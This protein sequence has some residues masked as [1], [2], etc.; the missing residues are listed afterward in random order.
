M[1]PSG[2]SRI[3]RFKIDIRDDTAMA[4]TLRME[5][6]QRYYHSRHS[7]HYLF[8][9][10]Y[11]MDLLRRQFAG[12]ECELVDITVHKAEPYI[13]IK[14]LLGAL[15]DAL[16][17]KTTLRSEF[18]LQP[19]NSGRLYRAFINN[20]FNLAPGYR[21]LELG[22]HDG[23]A[24]AAALSG[25]SIEALAVDDWSTKAGARLDFMK[26]LLCVHAPASRFGMLDKRM[27]GIFP[28]ALG[29]RSALVCQGAGAIAPGNGVIDVIL[30]STAETPALLVVDAWNFAPRRKD[31]AEVIEK[32]R[33]EPAVS[34]CVRTSL[35]GVHWGAKRNK[36]WA[37]GYFIA[38]LVPREHKKSAEP[39]RVTPESTPA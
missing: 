26:N 20:Y 2:K 32:S 22:S 1:H 25:N 29:P 23:A 37:E 17:Q 14:K 3:I 27:G 33:F 10:D 39:G 15:S 31:W 34:V 11:D 21:Y 5:Q 30:E 6:M 18:Y 19:G 4:A 13:P 24:F 36:R 8:A 38:I 16:V 28:S 7:N 12:K 35:D 9:E